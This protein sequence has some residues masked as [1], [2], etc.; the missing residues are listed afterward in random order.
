MASLE[1]RIT[2]LEQAV[3]LHYQPPNIVLHFMRAPDRFVC[4]YQ[5]TR[6][7]ESISQNDGESDADFVVRAKAAGFVLTE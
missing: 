4:R 5:R 2:A 1:N 6:T 7:G 3:G